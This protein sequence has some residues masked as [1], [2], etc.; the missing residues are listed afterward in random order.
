LPSS[1]QIQNILAPVNYDVIKSN[2]SDGSLVRGSLNHSTIINFFE[3]QQQPTTQQNLS[4][5]GNQKN[6][7]KHNLP[8]LLCTQKFNNN[9]QKENKKNDNDGE[10][11][12]KLT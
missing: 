9:N 5:K 8:E 7:L 3:I 6:N 4:N 10:C 2:L 12:S 1:Q 11:I